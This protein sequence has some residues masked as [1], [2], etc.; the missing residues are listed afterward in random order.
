[1]SRN[2]IGETNVNHNWKQNPQ[3]MSSDGLVD[4]METK[5]FLQEWICPFAL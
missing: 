4:D 1:M 2:Q 5:I 3:I